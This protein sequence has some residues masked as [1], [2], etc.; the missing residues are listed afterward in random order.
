MDSKT[1]TMKLPA[2]VVS[3]TPSSVSSSSGKGKN[4]D[5]VVAPPPFTGRATKP[6]D[7]N[8]GRGSL[9]D[10]MLMTVIWTLFVMFGLVVTMGDWLL[11]PRDRLDWCRAAQM[12]ANAI[13]PTITQAYPN[14]DANA[15]PCYYERTIY[16]MG[17]NQFEC[18]FARRMMYAT[19]LGACIGFERKSQD[20]PAGLR[21]MSL[22]SLGSAIFTMGG[23]FAFRSSTQ[24]WDA[25][26]VS[27]AIPSGVGFLGGALIWKETTGEKGPN[28]RN[29][30]HG[31]TTA[32]SVWLSASVGIAAG[33]A[34][35]VCS[36]WTV[37][38]VIFVL[39]FGPKMAFVD[40]ESYRTSD[41]SVSSVEDDDEWEEDPADDVAMEESLT[42]F[43]TKEKSRHK[44]ATFHS[45]RQRASAADLQS[46]RQLE[47]QQ[48]NFHSD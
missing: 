42:T 18:D 21:T 15:D 24:E 3:R 30:V 40:D 28:Q 26:R 7:L 19:I 32:A 16:L 2:K 31:I 6:V 5:V 38:L 37:I 34:L 39:R 8:I 23:Q 27:A 4:N 41:E 44:S 35:W 10:T 36:A 46:I 17:W 29:H 12:E 20:R 11:L 43:E 22:V 9:F 33:G 47:K 48:I 25:A 1:T 14:P 13:N 45:S